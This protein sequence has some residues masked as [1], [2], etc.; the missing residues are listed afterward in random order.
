MSW[1]AKLKSGLAKSSS[2]LTSGITD[3]FTKKKLDEAAL[4]QL[5]ELL[6]EADLGVA[7]AA[8]LAA[9]LSRQKFGKEISEQEVRDTLAGD[10]T[11]LLRP[12]AQPLRI[13]TRRTPFIIVVVGVNGNG[14]TT[15]I[16]KLAAQ[17]KAEGRSVMLAAA[18][19]FRAAAVEQLRAWADRIGV[20][21]IAGA[22]NA[23][24]ASVAY[25]ALERAKA[26]GAE[27]LMIDTA[28]RLHN[29][30]DLMAELEKIIRVL[31][32]IEP[33]APHAV[34][35]VLDATTGGNALAQV[36]MFKSV[37]GV[38]GLIVTKLDGTAKGG[39]VV[40]LAK[41]FGLPVHAVG[42]GEAIDDLQ[43]FDPEVFARQLVGGN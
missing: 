12:V 38:T 39:V 34:L 43:P 37:V 23:D 20:P 3:I 14:K 41:A 1:L 27:V 11:E 19:T 42:V 32:K 30:A 10:I 21:L 22:A 26:E 24:S 17:W 36:E 18:D 13:D 28:G 4:E 25:Q 5:E 33:S 29:K 7:A 40:A 8:E 6:I 16:A 2:K 35:Q 15:T 9:K 31:Q